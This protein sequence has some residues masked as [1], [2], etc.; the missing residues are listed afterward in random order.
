MVFCAVLDFYLDLYIP[1]GSHG[2]IMFHRRTES[3]VSFVGLESP[4][5]W[6]G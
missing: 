5:C 2:N 6:L 4:V 1:A 3:G